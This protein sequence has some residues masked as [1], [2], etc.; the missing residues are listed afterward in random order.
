M[1]VSKL[2]C[3]VDELYITGNQLRVARLCKSEE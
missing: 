3:I 2:G 1:A